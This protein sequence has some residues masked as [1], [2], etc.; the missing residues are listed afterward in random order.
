VRVTK[1]MKMTTY[2]DKFEGHRFSSPNDLVY[3]PD[4]S[5]YFT[6]PPYGLT[7]GD[8][9]PAKE[10][11]FNGVFQYKNGVVKAIIKDLPRPN[12]IGFS[13]DGKTM[14]VANSEDRK[15]YWM[16]YDVAADGSVS[17]GRMFFDL[18]DAADR[19]IPDGLKIDSKGNLWGAGPGGVWVISPEGKHL[20]TIQPGETAANLNWGDDGKTLYITASTSVYRIKLSVAGE[21]AMYTTFK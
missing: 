14:Y 16:R 8:T 12:G 10:I 20:G 5:L 9:D 15:R 2:I 21:K 19:G 6:D 11:P 3:G 4:G 1:D 13:P 18:N 17:N 7:R